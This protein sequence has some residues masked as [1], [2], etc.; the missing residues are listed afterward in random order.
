ML[1]IEWW[2]E[3]DVQ[4]SSRIIS[5]DEFLRDPGGALL[6]SDSDWPA[7]LRDTPILIEVE[8]DALRDSLQAHPAFREIM[9]SADSSI[10]AVSWRPIELPSQ[11]RDAAVR[12]LSA[13]RIESLGIAGGAKGREASGKPP[14]WTDNG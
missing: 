7:D 9:E 13:S 8:D 2:V 10:D 14:G 11:G 4:L 1:V 12:G 3:N 6:G 5:R